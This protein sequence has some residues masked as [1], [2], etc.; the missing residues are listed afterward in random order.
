MLIFNKETEQ[1]TDQP[2]GENKSLFN[3]L[4]MIYFS[5][6]TFSCKYTFSSQIVI[7]NAFDYMSMT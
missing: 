5:I 7:H 6:R 1:A 4:K 3:L 2:G